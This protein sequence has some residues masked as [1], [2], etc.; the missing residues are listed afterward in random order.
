MT[1]CTVTGLTAPLQDYLLSAVG[2]DPILGLFTNN[3]NG[4]D[5]AALAWM[6]VLLTIRVALP[7]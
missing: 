7:R 3:Q 2:K 4:A 5:G 6:L 1:D